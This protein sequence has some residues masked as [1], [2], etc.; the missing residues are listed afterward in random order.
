MNAQHSSS[1]AR[2]N[3]VPIKRFIF[4]HPPVRLYMPVFVFR[5][6]KPEILLFSIHRK[7]FYERNGSH[8]PVI[9]RTILRFVIVILHSFA[10]SC[11]F[12]IF[13]F[14]SALYTKISTCKMRF[15]DYNGNVSGNGFT[16][17]AP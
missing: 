2:P 13:H 15:F 11:I 14:F 4:L 3:T 9:F 5:P 1:A 12:Q 16:G 7:L 8:L 6:L 10:H 17:T